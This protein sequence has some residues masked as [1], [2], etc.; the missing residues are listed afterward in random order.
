MT[1]RS[2]FIQN[3][4]GASAAEFAIL[5]PVIG[6]MLFG[7]IKFGIVYNN[8]LSLTA[9]VANAERQFAVSRTSTT[10]ISTAVTALQT[11]APTL[12]TSQLK[13]NVLIG[14]TS[15]T[16]GLVASTSAASSDSGCAGSMAKASGTAST[17]TATY[18]CDLSVMGV[19]FGG[20]GCT[21]TA[22][23]SERIE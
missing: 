13:V 6:T 9:G 21:L 10:P 2:Q 8:Y 5:V 19:N 12:N 22:Q 23:A 14:A 17:L 3:R 15:C 1:L 4:S 7:L 16:G 20:A 11:T 18:P